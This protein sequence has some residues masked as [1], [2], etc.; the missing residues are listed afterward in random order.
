[1]AVMMKVMEMVQQRIMQQIAQSAVQQQLTKLLIGQQRASQE[2]HYV[3]DNVRAG[4]L[5]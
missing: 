5:F 3:N 4:G 1:M 2:R